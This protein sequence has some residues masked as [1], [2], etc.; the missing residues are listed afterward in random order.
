MCA[1]DGLNRSSLCLSYK[2]TEVVWKVNSVEVYDIETPPEGIVE[3]LARSCNI[4]TGFKSA[5]I[6]LTE[7]NT[8]HRFILAFCD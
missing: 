3:L 6:I 5:C 4:I 8:P 7:T 2:T 1:T